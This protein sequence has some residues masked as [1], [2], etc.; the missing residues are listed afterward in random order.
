M[1][2]ASMSWRFKIASS[3]MNSVVAPIAL[4]LSDTVIG[5]ESTA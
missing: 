3:S 1:E 5:T 4:A 2:K